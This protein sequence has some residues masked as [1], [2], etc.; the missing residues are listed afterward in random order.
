MKGLATFAVLLCVTAPAMAVEP[1]ATYRGNDQRTGNTDGIAGPKEPKVLWVVKSNDHY[2][3]SPVPW[4]DRL[5]VSGLGGFNVATFA[6]LST[7]P[8]AKERTLWIKST[9]YLKLPIVSSPAVTKG[10]QLVFGDGM[11]QTDGAIL[12]CM[13]ANS[14]LPLWQFPVPGRLVHLEGSPTVDNGRVYSG[15]GAAGVFCID[16]DKAVLDKKEMPL[17]AIQEAMTKRWKELQA[18]YDKEKLTNKFAVPPTEDQLPHPEP[19][20]HWRQGA[21]KWHVDA[22]VVVVGDKV[23]AA[24]AFLDNEKVGDRAVFCLDAKDGKVQWRF[25]LDLNPWAGPSVSGK[26]VVVGTSSINYDFNALKG[27]KGEIAA[28]NLDDGKIKWR[29]PVKGGVLAT[30]AL[31]KDLAVATATDGKVRGYDLAAG[32]PRFVYDAKYPIFAPA[33]VVGDTAYVGDLKG[34]LHAI[35]LSTG[36]ARWTLDLG[37]DPTVKAPGMIYGGPIVHGGRIYLATCNLAGVAA[38]QTTVI[39][40]IGEK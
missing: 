5:Y 26:T 23:L 20:Q 16:L 32:E 31:T 25:P 1:W 10:G 39:A 7:E 34:V 2:I 9:P 36:T 3:A 6:C 35:D 12:H 4:E 21:E 28:I 38:Q 15:G 22:P 19:K 27:A 30:V 40:C 24:S 37:T 18:A 29:K 14:G 13:V 8:K 17:T 33:A 11:H